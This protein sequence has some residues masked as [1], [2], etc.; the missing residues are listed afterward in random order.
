MAT[1]ELIRILLPEFAA[2]LADRLL[3]HGH[4]AFQEQFLDIAEA[5]AE[6]KVQPQSTATQRD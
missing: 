6:A 1:T 2:P 4:T 5:Q 3:R